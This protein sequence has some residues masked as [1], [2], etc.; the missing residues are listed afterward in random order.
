MKIR[1]KTF[2]IVRDVLGFD[3]KELTVSDEIAVTDVMTL[4]VKCYPG[5]LPIM[6]TLLYARNEEYCRTDT[7]LEDEDTLAIFPHV[8]GG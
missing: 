4:L 1:I 5:L 3:E 7:V 6:N 2:S 8:S